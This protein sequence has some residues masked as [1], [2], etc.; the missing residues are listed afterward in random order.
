MRHNEWCH[1]VE[2][3]LWNQTWHRNPA[4]PFRC[5]YT[6]WASFSYLWY[7]NK[8]LILQVDVRIG[9]NTCKCMAHN[10]SLM[11]CNWNFGERPWCLV[12]NVAQSNVESPE[13]SLP[14]SRAYLKQALTSGLV[15]GWLPQLVRV[16]L[17]DDIFC[18]S[19]TLSS[20]GQ[21]RSI[22]ITLW[23]VWA[24]REQRWI[25][26]VIVKWTMIVEI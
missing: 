12:G 11:N 18:L 2:E 4:L 6:H 7:G 5:I 24:L 15:V 9:N 3:G 26:N 1:E 14:S 16:S 10:Q 20:K 17:S 21:G 25:L 8:I 22:F 13:D 23:F 19:V